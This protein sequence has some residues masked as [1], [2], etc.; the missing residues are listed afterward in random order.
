MQRSLLS[1][2]SAFISIMF[3]FSLFSIQADGTAAVPEQ[4]AIGVRGGEVR[5]RWR[6]PDM[7]EQRFFVF[8]HDEPVTGENIG[9][10]QLVAVLPAGSE[11]YTEQVEERGEYH[12]AVV[13]EDEN[14]E[15]SN[16]VLPGENATERAVLVTLEPSDPGQQA[17]PEE[18]LS[19]RAVPQGDSVRLSVRTSS[20]TVSIIILRT[21]EQPES[22]TDMHQSYH[23]VGRAEGTTVELQDELVPGIP[24]WYTAVKSDAFDEGRFPELRA[25]VNTL[26]SA[27]STGPAMP[28]PPVNTRIGSER[29]LR[30]ETILDIRS[31]LGIHSDREVPPPALER[32]QPV[33]LNERTRAAVERMVSTF[34]E[35]SRRDEQLPAAR[36]TVDEALSVENSHLRQIT[37]MWARTGDSE[38]ATMDLR[39]LLAHEAAGSES[40]TARYYLGRSEYE[41]GNAREALYQ[42]LLV[43][44]DE[45]RDSLRWIRAI[46]DEGLASTP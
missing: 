40:A 3:L 28:A 20:E 18:V 2:R 15:P 8:M 41:R 19:M 24:A 23:V 14:R 35:Q 17:E 12:F 42:F 45:A 1:R 33:A 10:A 7:Y 31:D 36:P 38:R 5:L 37:E 39:L 32:V 13:T 43:D 27:V 25:G 44:G 22:G 46:L 11:Q 4:L 9:E 16:S 34:T 21:L 29:T 6:I 30:R 26:R